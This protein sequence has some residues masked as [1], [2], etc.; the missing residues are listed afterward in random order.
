MQKGDRDIWKQ[1]ARE[2]KKKE[3]KFKFSQIV[4]LYSGGKKRC[5]NKCQNK[6]NSEAKPLQQT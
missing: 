4:L 3:W 5:V 2:R 6:M 1:K